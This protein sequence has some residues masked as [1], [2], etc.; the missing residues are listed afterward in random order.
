[1]TQTSDMPSREAVLAILTEDAERFANDESCRREIFNKYIN[2]IIVGKENI[3]FEFSPYEAF[4]R[5]KNR[6]SKL[7]PV[8]NHDKL[9]R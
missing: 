8:D 7:Y 2:A 1:M 5:K 9:L 6:G 3:R 4:E